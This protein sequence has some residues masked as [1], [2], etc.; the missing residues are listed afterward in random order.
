MMGS[1]QI[2]HAGKLHEIDELWVWI[3]C[4]G[5]LHEIDAFV[6]WKLH[7]LANFTRATI[8]GFG[9]RANAGELR[10]IDEFEALRV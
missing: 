5:R 6:I 4:F 9:K 2:E 1:G 7:T 3:D 8:L 10:E